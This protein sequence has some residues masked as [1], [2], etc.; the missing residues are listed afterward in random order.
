MNAGGGVSIYSS[1]IV[2]RM[3][4]RT[5]DPAALAELTIGPRDVNTNQGENISISSRVLY[6]RVRS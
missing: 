4:R 5:R 6:V 2:E 1:G 3:D